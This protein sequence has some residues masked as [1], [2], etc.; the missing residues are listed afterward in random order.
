MTFMLKKVLFIDSFQ[1]P[2]ASLAHLSPFKPF[3]NA[4]ICLWIK[5]LS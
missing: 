2:A 4:I 3:L 1:S 5:T